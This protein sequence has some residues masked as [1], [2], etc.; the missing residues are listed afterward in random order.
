MLPS[1]PEPQR[2]EE[3]RNTLN[4]PLLRRFFVMVLGNFLLGTGLALFKVSLMGM[5][6]SN[7]LIMA[8]SDVLGVPFPLMSITCCALF[9]IVEFAW[10]R[11]H[12]NMGTFVNWFMVGPTAGYF[13]ALIEENHL[14]HD[15]FPAHLLVM[16]C[17]VLVLSLGCS[18]YQSSKLGI[19]PYDSLSIILSE[20]SRYKYFWCRVFTDFICVTSAAMLGGVV[21]LGTLVCAFGMGPFI[22]FFDVHISRKLCGGYQGRTG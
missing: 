14:V 6:P 1:L 10:G 18:M 16:C 12:I 19:S 5:A 3:M 9:F 13:M 11:E 8:I 2:A 15:S 20:R 4:A 21:G 22:S 17:G 7:S